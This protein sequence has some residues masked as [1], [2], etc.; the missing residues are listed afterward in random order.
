MSADRTLTVEDFALALG[1]TPNQVPPNLQEQ[2]RHSD[3]R[4]QTLAP[5][6]RDQVILGIL[7]RLESGELSKVGEHRK[8]VWEKG[9]EENLE[10]FAQKGFAL[11]NL[12]PRFIR[13]EPIVRLNRD[14]VCACNPK[15]EF[16]FHDVVRRWLFLQYMADGEAVYE[17]GCGSGYNLVTFSE[18]HPTMRLVGLDWAE[19]SVKLV[20]L[21]AKTH[22]LNL[23]GVR[24][25][26]FHPDDSLGLGPRDVALTICA[27]EQVGTRHEEFLQ[28]LLRKRPRL[29]VHMEPLL[30]LYDPDNLVDYLAIRFH[31]GRGYLSGFLERLRQLETQKRIEIV[32]VQRMGFGSLYHEGYS[33]IVWRSV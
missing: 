17:F 12:V 15:V 18:I 13:P 32:K 31:T 27:L 6:E 23:Q 11:E 9:W 8:E 19:S 20:N 21:I 24:F 30:D 5:V 22:Q 2:I 33:Y 16:H 1:V 10:A 28:F 29:C 26:L 3:F 14:Y 4:Y 25:D 7:K